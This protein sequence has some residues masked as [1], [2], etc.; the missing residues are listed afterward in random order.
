MAAR[1]TEA[2][3]AGEARLARGSRATRLLRLC[4]TGVMDG[5]R[6]PSRLVA[7]LMLR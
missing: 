6:L 5:L 7:K 2:S 1:L 4:L 3:R